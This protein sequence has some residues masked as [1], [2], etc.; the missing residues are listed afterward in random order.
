MSCTSALEQDVDDAESLPGCFKLKVTFS[1]DQYLTILKL[2]DHTTAVA[3]VV[4]LYILSWRPILLNS[5][6]D[7]RVL[8]TQ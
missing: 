2:K 4:T 1:T 7:S 6:S 8:Q 5:S 3:G